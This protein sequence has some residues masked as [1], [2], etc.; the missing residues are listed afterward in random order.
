MS[1][2]DLTSYVINEEKVYKVRE[3]LRKTSKNICESGEC[4]IIK[5]NKFSSCEICNKNF[6]KVC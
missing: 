6:C 1:F 5:M 4:Y 2:L 3:N